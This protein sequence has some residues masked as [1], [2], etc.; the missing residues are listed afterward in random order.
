MNRP[1]DE[2]DHF[3]FTLDDTRTVGFELRSLS[4]DAHL[5]LNDASGGYLAGSC[6]S[7]DALDTFV[8]ELGSGT[9]YVSVLTTYDRRGT[10]DYRLRVGI[11]SEP[12][13]GTRETAINLGDLA[14]LRSA[15]TRSGAVNREGT[16]EQASNPNDYYRFTLTETRTL[17]FQLRDLSANANLY[18]ENAS[19]RMDPGVVS[20]RHLR[21]FDRPHARRR[22]LLHPDRCL[23]FRRHPLPASLSGAN[24][25]RRTDTRDGVQHRQPDQPHVLPHPLGHREHAEQPK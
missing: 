7:G 6:R 8:R 10:S 3:R 25:S 5:Y 1:R 14:G 2:I 23:G 13:G 12:A 18:L 19:G 11:P 22:D 16:L 17:R 21:R 24:H 9:Y 20:P 4:G 15:R